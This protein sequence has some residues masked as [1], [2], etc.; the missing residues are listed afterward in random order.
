VQKLY[1]GS[2]VTRMR[3]NHHIP[4]CE[5][6]TRWAELIACVGATFHSASTT[7]RTRTCT[8]RRAAPPSQ[9]VGSGATA[10]GASIRSCL[11]DCCDVCRVLTDDWF[12]YNRGGWGRWQWGWKNDDW[13]PPRKYASFFKLH[14]T[15]TLC[16][17]CMNKMDAGVL[18]VE[19]EWVD[20]VSSKINEFC[21]AAVGP[22][23]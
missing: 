6:T 13:K 7:A 1:P 12:L 10:D 2:H 3:L 19:E 18:D 15:Y 4:P 20:I 5:H 17:Q 8:S 21:S 9:Q 22:F 14:R 11:G 16:D 23:F